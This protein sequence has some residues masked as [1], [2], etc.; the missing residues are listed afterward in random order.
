M[1]ITKITYQNAYVTGPYLQHKPGFEAEL[2]ERED[3]IEALMKLKAIADAFDK[4]VNN[5]EE[6]LVSIDSPPPAIQINK[7]QED[8]RIGVFKEDIMSCKDIQTLETYKLLIK[9][10]PELE[11]AYATRKRQI[12]EL[13]QKQ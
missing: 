13:T 4:R 1:T 6:R 9:G 10:K 5:F 11:S 8:I 12:L 2:E 7:D 3:P